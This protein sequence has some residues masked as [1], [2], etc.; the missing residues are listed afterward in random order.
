MK[1]AIILLCVVV[2]VAVLSSCGISQQ[3]LDNARQEGYDAGYDDG[4]MEAYTMGYDFGYS[5]GYKDGS[6]SWHENS[7]KYQGSTT[8]EWQNTQE[9]DSSSSYEEIRDKYLPGTPDS[10]PPLSPVP[11]PVSGTI[12]SG[13]EYG[14]SSIT[15]TA[16]SSSSYV[17][18]LKTS[19]GVERV[20]FYI[21][22]GETVTIGVP[23]EYLY[24]YFASGTTWYGYGD[25][26][27]FG[28]YTAYSK[29]DDLLDFTQ[30]TWE[31]TLYPVYDGNFSETPSD[32]QEF[33]G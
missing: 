8:S 33:F 28:D 32:A 21:R 12:L 29:D 27:M 17:V 6:D 2:F 4:K 30:Y 14:D 11:E 31:Y 13:W 18:S 25:G 1:K 10:V 22:A 20:T 5:N 19:S 26:L 9:Q 15:V 7:P 16:D 23:A 3:D 24:V